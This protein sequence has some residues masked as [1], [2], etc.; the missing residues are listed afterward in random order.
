MSE[1]HWLTRYDPDDGE[2]YGSVCDCSIGA[3]HEGDGR[4][5]YAPESAVVVDEPDTTGE[6]TADGAA[7]VK[8]LRQRVFAA[9]DA[10]L[11]DTAP[12][13]DQFSRDL[14][15]ALGSLLKF[16]M[17]DHPAVQA[18]AR[19]LLGESVTTE[20]AVTWKEDVPPE[21]GSRFEADPDPEVHTT[22]RRSIRASGGTVWTCQVLHGP[23]QVENPGG[24]S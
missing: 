9:H 2:P 24:E 19:A 21:R 12:R 5:T 3:D 10:A 6:H 13:S 14:G 7:L 4:L 18:V 11:K 22:V 20:W 16:M 1:A 23:W 15:L 17:R 8:L